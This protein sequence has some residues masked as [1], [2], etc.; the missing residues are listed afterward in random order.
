V[1]YGRASDLYDRKRV[2]QSALVV[3]LIGSALAGTARSLDQ[4][5]AFRALQGLGGGGLMALATAVVADMVPPRQRGRY[6][7]YIGGVLALATVAG[8]RCWWRAG[9]APRRHGARR[10]SWD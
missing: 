2:F 9:A 3:F 5:I 10:A 8:A 7:G 6:V 1:L 4:L